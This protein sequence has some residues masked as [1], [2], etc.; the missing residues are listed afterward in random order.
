VVEI[1]LA[2]IGLIALAI[3]T[4]GIANALLAAVRERRREIGVLKAIGARDRDVQR[5]F[6]VEAGVLGLLGGLL[7]TLAGLGLASLVGA[8]VNGY[9]RSQGLVGVRPELPLA[10]AVAGV[11]GAG[12][13]AVAAGTVPARRAARLPAREAVEA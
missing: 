1:V 4:L 12:L 11:L 2:G 3:A 5:L 7:G 9:L 6:L 8:V 13:L 10:I